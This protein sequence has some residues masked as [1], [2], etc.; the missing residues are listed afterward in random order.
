VARLLLDASTPQCGGGPPADGALRLARRSASV[1]IRGPQ[2]AMLSHRGQTSRSVRSTDDT[3]MEIVFYFPRN[4]DFR[5]VVIEMNCC[6][7]LD[8]ESD[9]PKNALITSNA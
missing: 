9:I 7:R 8:R 3:M 5:N 6:L 2:A 4:L 1:G